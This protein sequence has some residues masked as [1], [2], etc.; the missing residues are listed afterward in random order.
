M[1][2][3]ESMS[4]RGSPYDN[5]KAESFM[6]S[7]KVE[8]VYLAAYETFE[9]VTADPP[10]FIDDV[11]VCIPHSAISALCNSRINTPSKGSKLRLDR[12]HPQGRTPIGGRYCKRAHT[13]GCRPDRRSQSHS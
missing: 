13:T 8:A 9:D 1:A 2:L 7:L 12:V 3:V 6:K 11:S 4:R 5:A 10:R